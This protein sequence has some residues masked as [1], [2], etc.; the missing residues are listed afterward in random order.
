MARI[1]EISTCISLR[2]NGD[3]FVFLTQADAREWRATGSKTGTILFGRE[4]TR[5]SKYIGGPCMRRSL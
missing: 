1:S 4:A 5:L 3:P 2:K